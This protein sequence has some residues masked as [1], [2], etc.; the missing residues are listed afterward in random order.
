MYPCI[1]I[2][3][4]LG[5]VKCTVFIFLSFGIFSV[6]NTL[7]TPTKVYQGDRTIRD[8]FDQYVPMFLTLTGPNCS[9]HRTMQV[10]VP[11]LKSFV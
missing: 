3:I 5:I 10:R 4:H 2:H 8:Y 1:V 7:F 9:E 6:V 11:I